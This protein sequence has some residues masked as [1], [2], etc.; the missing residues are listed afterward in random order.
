MAHARQTHL[1]LRDAKFN[2]LPKE[3]EGD[4]TCDPADDRCRCKRDRQDSYC[5]EH[6]CAVD[7]D[8]RMYITYACTSA[9]HACCVL[10]MHGILADAHKRIL[11]ASTRQNRTSDRV[12]AAGNGQ[13]GRND[14][15]AES[16]NAGQSGGAYLHWAPAR[17]QGLRFKSRVVERTF[18]D[19]REQQQKESGK[20]RRTLR[21]GLGHPTATPSPSTTAPTKTPAA[22]PYAL[23]G[24]SVLLSVEIKFKQPRA[25]R[26]GAS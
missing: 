15:V 18:W 2:N 26:T 9:A 17:A 7:R 22:A 8:T 3:D 4:R 21:T 16:T 5:R 25:G 12:L 10:C 23:A 13:A 11:D 20:L 1:L 6:A 19:A 24:I 14:G